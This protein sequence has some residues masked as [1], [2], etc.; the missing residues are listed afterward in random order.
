MATIV[1]YPWIDK[2]VPPFFVNDT[3]V[4]GDQTEAAA[5]TLPNGRFFAAWTEPLGASATKSV[6]ARVIKTDGTP[7]A[8]QFQANSTDANDQFDPSLATL[9]NG[10]V[11]VT[12]TDTSVHANG[13]IRGR[14]F[15]STGTALGADFPVAT[16]S[17][18]DP[19]VI[20]RDSQSSVAALAGGQFAV[21]WRDEATV[22]GFEFDSLGLRVFNANGSPATATSFIGFNG[23]PFTSE[24]PSIAALASGGFVVVWTQQPVG[25]GDSEVRFA[26]FNATGQNVSN[27]STGVLLDAAGSINRD[28]HVTGLPDGGFAVAYTDNAVA[29]GSGIDISARVFNGDGSPRSSFLAV[30][31]VT[32]GSQDDATISTLANGGFVVGFLDLASGTGDNYYQQAYD[33]SGN[34]LGPNHLAAQSVID[35]QTFALAGGL[36][37]SIDESNQPEAGGTGHSIRAG[38]NELTRTIVGDGAND[39]FTG[40]QLRDTFTGNGGSDVFAYKPGG[41]ADLYTDFS[42]GL[43][44]LDKIDLTGFPTLHRLSDILALATQVG[45]DTVLNFGGGDNLTLQNVLKADLSV[46]DFVSLFFDYDAARFGDFDNNGRADILF[47]NGDPAL[48]AAIWQTNSSGALSGIVSLGPVPAGFRIDGTGNFNSTAGDDILLRSPTSVAVWPMSGFSPQSVQI[49]GGTSPDWHNSGIGDFTGDGQSDLL[50]R[51]ANTGEIATWGIANNALSTTPKVLGSTA[52]EYHIVA[53]DDFTGD[54]QA[55]I[56]FR[57]DNGDI[58]IWRVANN[59]LA[60]VPSVVGS[61]P[62]SFHVVG[63]GDFDGNGSNDILF[64]DD[65]G[66]VAMW[67]LNSSGALLGSPAAIGTAGN[68]FHV[69]GTGD[70]NGDARSDIVFRDNAGHVV[71][72]LMNGTSFAAPPAVVGTASLDYSIAAHQF[73]LI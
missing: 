46:D 71:E 52:P 41:N 57:H 4:A 2:V 26:L 1:T 22:H 54:H 63:V 21:V 33:A 10:N 28:I 23:S 13:D 15:T 36:V 37:G 53:V 29:G 8:S 20:E 30:N 61:A 38:I 66:T 68:Q 39:S 55:D 42:A 43:G 16:V 62:N 31:D 70:L 6:Q 73:D 64:R 47:Q 27:S 58:A 59:A 72:W 48:P 19:Q 12:F 25:G 32:A 45:N 44:T 67:L 35:A 50:F 34:P 11:V 18:S 9:A 17:T 40:D 56:L 7:L 60:G 69:D 65:G 49:L 5:T 51:N 3:F 24:H 14:V